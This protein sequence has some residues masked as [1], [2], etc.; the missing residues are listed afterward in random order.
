MKR[1][2]R[3][4]VSAEVNSKAPFFQSVWKFSRIP[5]ESL[6]IG[7]SSSTIK[8]LRN[9]LCPAAA[10]REVLGLSEPELINGEILIEP[11]TQIIRKPVSSTY[12]ID[13]FEEDASH[14]YPTASFAFK[15]NTTTMT[16]QTCYFSK[17]TVFPQCKERMLIILNTVSAQ[18]RKS[19]HPTREKL[20]GWF[21]PRRAYSLAL[22]LKFD[23]LLFVFLFVSFFCFFVF[24]TL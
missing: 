3:W 11:L 15:R 20:A 5:I 7:L 24:W 10:T 17:S 21:T 6:L 8:T 4:N 18:H 2:H 19:A 12:L 16:K 9:V 1:D 14:Q 22:V 13:S 23:F